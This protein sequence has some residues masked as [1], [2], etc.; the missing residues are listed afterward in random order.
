MAIVAT[1]GPPDGGFIVIE[2]NAGETAIADGHVG[3]D[4]WL[5]NYYASVAD[6]KEITQNH[7]EN[8]KA[9]LLRI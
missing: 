5:M 8:F 1:F 3:D 4:Y 2:R 7:P 9:F 6:F